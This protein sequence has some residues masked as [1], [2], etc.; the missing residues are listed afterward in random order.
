MCDEGLKM[1]AGTRLAEWLRDFEIFAEGSSLVDD[2]QAKP[3]EKYADI[4]KL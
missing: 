4:F 1:T 2:T 3:T